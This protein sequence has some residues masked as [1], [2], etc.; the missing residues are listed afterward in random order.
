M[1]ITVSET[2]GID[3]RFGYYDQV[4][5]LRDM[6]QNHL[7]QLLCLVA[8]EPPNT[9]TAHEVAMKKS[10]LFAHFESLTTPQCLTTLFVGNTPRVGIEQRN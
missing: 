4:G 8:M 3:G 7:M 2:V 5:Q 1:Q 10:K 6:L 9:M